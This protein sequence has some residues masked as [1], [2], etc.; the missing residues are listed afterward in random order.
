MLMYDFL[1]EKSEE[2][3]YYIVPFTSSAQAALEVR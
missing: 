2:L 1:L 3:V